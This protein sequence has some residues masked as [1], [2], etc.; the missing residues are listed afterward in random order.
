MLEETE[1]VANFVLNPIPTLGGNGPHFELSWHINASQTIHVL[2]IWVHRVV[3]S[4]ISQ[5]IY[6]PT[7]VNPWVGL[8][9]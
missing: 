7:M 2:E 4:H 3:A 6:L 1:L 8:K 9:M 5:M